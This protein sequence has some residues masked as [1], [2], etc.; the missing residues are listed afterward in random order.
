MTLPLED[1]RVVAVEQY[2]AGPFGTLHLADLGAEVIKV[3][4]PRTAG[5][6]G[7]YVPPFQEG[8]DSLFF[9]TFNRNKKSVSLDL[10]TSAGRDVLRSLVGVSDAIFYNLRGD[11]PERL[12]LRYEQLRDVNPRVVCVSLSGY[13][14][15]GN[16][17]ADPAYDYVVQGLAGWMS[18]TGEP[19]GPPEKT[20]PSLVDYCGGLVAALALVSAVHAARRDGRGMECDLSLFDTAVGLL[21]YP[22]TWHLTGGFVPGRTSHSAHPSIVPFQSFEAADGWI[23]VACPK[24]RFWRL[25]TEVIGHP[26]LSADPRYASFEARRTHR[27]ELVAFLSEVFATRPAAEWLA[28]LGEVG[29]PCGPV[30][31]VPAA[32]ADPLVAERDLVV[33]TEHPR[34]GP[35]RSPASPV[36]VGGRRGAARRAPARNEHGEEVLRDLLGL[37]DGRIAE[38][39]EAG[40]F[41]GE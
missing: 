36:R 11:L 15:E 24:E 30:N 7:R 38:L 41:G 13:G 19:D 9:E 1:V 3:E 35:V 20:G 27:G 33:E 8:E 37:G 40:A 16:R 26:E 18:L 31:T 2:G 21:G 39:G 22:A 12:G 28:A 25:L 29:I 34:L 4:D 14:L 32:L 17:R 10:S 23:I 6:V 5:D